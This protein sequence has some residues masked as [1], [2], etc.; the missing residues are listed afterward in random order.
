[1][2]SR[3]FDVAGDPDD[4][5][6]LECADYLITGNQKQ[7]PQFWKKTKIITSREFIGLAASHL[8]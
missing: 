6:F 4:N 3:R 2:P 1:V 7:F 5:I 8:S